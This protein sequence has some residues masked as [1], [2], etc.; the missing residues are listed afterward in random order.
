MF[1]K[2]KRRTKFESGVSIREAR[3]VVNAFLQKAYELAGLYMLQ[4]VYPLL[5][6]YFCRLHDPIPPVPRLTC[7]EGWVN[8]LRF[9]G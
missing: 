6:V 4:R 7:L 3:Q 5:C 2:A 1:L 9:A 8:W